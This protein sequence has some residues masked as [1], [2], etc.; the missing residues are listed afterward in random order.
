MSS[1]PSLAGVI[2]WPIAHSRSPALHG[3]WLA[4]Y[5]LPGYYVPLAVAPEH[6]RDVLALLPKMG[7]RGVNVTIPHKETALAL[8]EETTERAARIGAANT[9][10]F[11]P[12]GGFLADNTDGIGFIEN[13]RQFAPGWAASSG[14][15]LV[16]GAGGAA[17][18]VVDAL[19]QEG[20][21]EVR[22]ANRTRARADALAAT[23][24]GR[25]RAY[26]WS[27]AEEA[28]RDCATIVN[29]TSLG[30]DGQAPLDLGF[31]TADPNALVT[32]IVYQPLITPFL[33]RAREAGLQTIDGLGMLL[34]QAAPG[35][36]AWFGRQPDV[37]AAL[38]EVV[39]GAKA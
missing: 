17:R 4:R 26:G 20:A 5:G 29:T 31:K 35:F 8:A 32:D 7:F 23:F 27:T 21:R 11:L 37:D 13:L 16:L 38:R 15:A 25:S 24:G 33:A 2:G 14:A 36:E 12:S 9:L 18:A 19:I 28:M 34:H 39:L 3:H 22:I 1:G 6:F 10:T 30:M